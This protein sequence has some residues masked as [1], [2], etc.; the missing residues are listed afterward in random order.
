[1]ILYPLTFLS[2]FWYF[3]RTSY[4]TFDLMT[5]NESLAIPSKL[6]L[7]LLLHHLCVM[8]LG[9]LHIITQ[10]QSQITQC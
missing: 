1:M 5:Y 9:F 3:L 2:K 7:S 6:P 4:Q 8:S 10:H